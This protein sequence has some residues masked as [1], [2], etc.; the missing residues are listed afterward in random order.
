MAPSASQPPH[1][2]SNDDRPGSGGSAAS[3]PER[4]PS[5]TIERSTP[6]GSPAWSKALRRA[7]AR[8]SLERII[9]AVSMICGLGGLWLMWD[10]GKDYYT[11]P[12]VERIYSDESA[13]YGTT[14][15]LGLLCGA[16]AMLLFLS[17]FG[18]FLRKHVRLLD[19][20]GTLRLWLDWHIASAF[21]GCGYVAL[22]ANFEMRNW[23][24]RVC[25]YALVIVII[26]GLIG[27]YLLRYVP[28]TATG[29]QLDEVGFTDEIMELIDQ[30]RA[31]V[32]HD[33]DA[34]I[35]MQGLIDE[36]NVEGAPTLAQLR[37][38][39]RECR[40]YVATIDR[41]LA[42]N[43]TGKRRSEA[44]A[45]RRRLGRFG[46][47]AAVV[48]WAGRI[49]AAWRA[50]HRTFALLLLVGMIAHVGFSLYYGY[51]AFWK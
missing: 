43:V 29:R 39:L 25:V 34:V 33:R 22:H 20:V 37:R 24:V 32:V 15:T 12:M 49:M 50:F 28:R 14:G 41:A 48:H 7:L 45:L 23:I 11:A 4:S 36:L 2:S 27:R 51:G 30:V 31:D 17:N 21:I 10:V 40:R 35:A 47:Q 5:G 3:P 19:R 8:T 16:I 26:T 18:Y 13:L 6:A 42:A 9:L 46:M 38:R 44:R 1:E